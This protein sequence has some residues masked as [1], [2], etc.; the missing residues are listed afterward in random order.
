MKSHQLIKKEGYSNDYIFRVVERDMRNMS[1]NDFVVMM[2]DLLNDV[3]DEYRSMCIEA[4]NERIPELIDRHHR[5]LMRQYSKKLDA[6]KRESSRTKLLSKIDEQVKERVE[7][8]RKYLSTDIFWDIMPMCFDNAHP[9][10]TIVTSKSSDNELR[11]NYKEFKKYIEMSSGIVFKY[12]TT[13]DETVD[14]PRYAFRPWIEFIIPDD[15]MNDLQE[16][17]RQTDAKIMEFYNSL[18]YKGD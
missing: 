5:D 4:F 10:Y 12:E 17:K 8:C 15:V 18:G 16:T 14:K 9:V 6:Y 7:Q 11:L 13:A 1:E 3:A 2:R